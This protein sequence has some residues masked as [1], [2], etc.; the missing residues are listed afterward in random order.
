MKI[1]DLRKI[2]HDPVW[3][4]V[5][6]SVIVAASAGIYVIAKSLLANISP[7]AVLANLTTLFSFSVPLWVVFLI[8]I[9]TPI[10]YLGYREL[11]RSKYISI[12]ADDVTDQKFNHLIIPA[13]EVKS[14]DQLIDLILET[15][16]EEGL[17]NC[18]FGN[19]WHLVD[20]STRV[21]I[22]KR[23]RTSLASLGIKGGSIVEI[24]LFPWGKKKMIGLSQSRIESG[25]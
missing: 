17:R 11:A 25:S 19:D 16:E 23:S 8:L 10:L 2:W 21:T 9:A 24:V 20:Q 4:K 18:S 6:A 3:S 12:R 7:F 13:T 15:F 14:V 22:N 1:K 5:I